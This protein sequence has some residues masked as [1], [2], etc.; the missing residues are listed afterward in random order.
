MLK[1]FLHQ[2][3]RGYDVM[4]GIWNKGEGWRWFWREYPIAEGFHMEER[5][6]SDV[7]QILLCKTFVRETLSRPSYIGRAMRK[8]VLFRFTCDFR[9]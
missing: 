1:N 7:V 9:V 3:L 6:I 2:L 5:P 8:R 4:I